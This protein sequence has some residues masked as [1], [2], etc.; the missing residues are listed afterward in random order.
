ML[1]VGEFGDTEAF[2]FLNLALGLEGGGFA[3]EFGELGTDDF[4]GIKD[5]LKV[6]IVEDDV[7][8]VFVAAGRLGGLVGCHHELLGPGVFFPGKSARAVGG[9]AALIDAEGVCGL[10]AG[11]VVGFHP[12]EKP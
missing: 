8:F 9:E 6:L 12:V 11:D 2:D 3:N 5:E 10:G 7:D 1:G 4:R